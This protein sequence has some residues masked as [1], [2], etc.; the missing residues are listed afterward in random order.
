MLLWL[1]ATVLTRI[2][3]AGEGF[4]RVHIGTADAFDFSQLALKPDHASR[5]FW[6]TPTGGVFL[7]GRCPRGS[8]ISL[9][10]NCSVFRTWN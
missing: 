3:A 7:E 9:F 8:S 1:L 2:Y 4:G 6:V 10:S 5:P